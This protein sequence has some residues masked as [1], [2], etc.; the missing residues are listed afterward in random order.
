VAEHM[1]MIL[2]LNKKTHKAYNRVRDQNFSLNGLL[3]FDLFGKTIGVL[4]QEIWVNLYENCR[5][6]GV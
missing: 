3:G 5:F 6:W 4:V 2:T 1:A